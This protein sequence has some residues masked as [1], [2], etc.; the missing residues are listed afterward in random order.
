VWIN[1]KLLR[2]LISWIFV[3]TALYSPGCEAGVLTATQSKYKPA[4]SDISVLK[5]AT[6]TLTVEEMEHPDVAARFVPL[7]GPLGYVKEVVWLRLRLSRLED[8]PQWWTLEFTNPFVND[9]RL[10]S[11]SATGF[12]VAQAGD[13]FPFAQRALKFHFPVFA[14]GFPD[15]QA[16]TFYLRLD[17]DSSLSGELLVWQSTA[18]R[19]GAQHEIF[20]YGAVLGMI[21]MSFLIS[22]IHWT[23]SRERKLLLL[24][25][26]TV[27][28]FFLVAIGLGLVAQFL[29]PT[30]PVI[31]DLMVP[32]SLAINTVLVGLVFGKVLNIQADF[33]RMNQFFKLTYVIAL[34]APFTR[35]FGM[36]NIWG[37]PLLQFVSMVVVLCTGW[38]SWRRWRAQVRGTG[39]FFSAHVVLV[40]SM[41]IGR[42]IL[43]GWLPANGLTQMSWIPGLLI[44]IF[45]AHVGF[46]VDSQSVKR[47]RDAAFREV[48]TANEVLV[49]E[50]K[51][52]A[53]QTVF[54]S[55][56][57]HELRS[58]LAAILTGLKNLESEL[59]G[60]SP[61]ALNRTHRLK[62]YA[63]RMSSLID[64]HL[65]L[66]RL[67]NADFLPQ[68]SLVDPRQIAE[69]ALRR[70]RTLFADRV[71]GLDY[72]NGLPASAR[73][74]QDLLL[75]GLENLLINAAKF[76]PQS[77][78]IAL[79]VLADE[80]L[81]FRVSD[82]GPGIP[83]DQI[84]RLFS[85]FNRM[86]QPAVKAGFGI[87]LA[88]V[89][90]IA[91]VHGGTLD[92]ADRAGGGAV[93][94]LTVPLSS[95]EPDGAA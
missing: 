38:L 11:R 71:F 79:E 30:A 52:R 36:Y 95:D 47:E 25:L 92:Y 40:G 83:P 5:D 16:Q 18:L 42:M 43:L 29:T 19:E 34:A 22:V 78:P 75:M 62:A 72:A 44:Y 55:F 37:G 90:R 93:F 3:F 77:T 66:Q 73:I 23:Y 50:R 70:V 59:V 91:L 32:W 89:Q 45:L 20:Y 51:M 58:P 1:R 65:T 48:K 81:H 7:N 6:G 27:S 61:Q 35:Q 84:G 8:A 74:D 17:S 31:S 82:R 80:A 21:C 9:L 68:L 49:I 57:A 28:T 24:A 86:P 46:F 2:A 88:I 12:S 15:T 26:L 39:Y 33:R 94:T 4:G 60:V 53:E 87:G 14:L 54:F 13:Q 69:E 85:I 76:S 67:R 63:E 56:V 10:Y 64:R 41:L